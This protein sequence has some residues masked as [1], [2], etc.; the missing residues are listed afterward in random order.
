MKLKPGDEIADSIERTLS[1]EGGY[2]N[3]PVDPGGETKFGISK[4]AFP[5]IDIKS[6]TKPD[7]IK[8]YRKEYW[9]KLDDILA[10]TKVKWKVFDMA[11]NMGVDT[12][13]AIWV[14]VKDRD[15]DWTTDRLLHE[16]SSTQMK[17]YVKIIKRNPVLVKYL[18]GWTN[19]AMEV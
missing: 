10:P 3:D 18:S 2:V 16:L 4:R 11:V 8:I 15:E 13:K 1:F 7:A 14:T 19:R 17:Y 12:A 9:D 6:L 5:D